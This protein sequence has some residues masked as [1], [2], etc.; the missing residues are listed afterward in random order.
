[1]PLRFGDQ[2]L[3][4]TTGKVPPVGHVPFL[5]EIQGRPEIGT[6]TGR[7]AQRRQ[8]GRGRLATCR[9]SKVCRGPSPVLF[10]RRIG[11]RSKQHRQA[12]YWGGLLESR[13]EA[14]C[15]QRRQV[16]EVQ[17]RDCHGVGAKDRGSG[18]DQA[19]VVRLCCHAL[20]QSLQ[21]VRTIVVLGTGRCA[22]R[23]ERD[24]N[25]A[26]SIPTR[27]VQCGLSKPVDGSGISLPREQ[28]RRRLCA[29]I[30]PPQR[31]QHQG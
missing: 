1:M 27:N 7:G 18:I 29:K 4:S 8:H 19:W 26:L 14:E 22:A 16:P 9:S 20:A 10:S 17:T 2:M 23:A 31:H 15:V 24:H 3:T 11:V 28:R 12:K 21:R 6:H 5:L 25:A 30:I 13:K